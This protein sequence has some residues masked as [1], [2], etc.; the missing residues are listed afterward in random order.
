MKSL[1]VVDSVFGNTEQVARVMHDVLLPF[2]EIALM[3]PDAVSRELFQGVDLLVVGSPTRGFRPTPAITTFL[4]TTCRGAIT[5][6]PV[7]AFDTRY[8]PD[9][10]SWA[11]RSIMRLCGF[12]A[13]FIAKELQKQGGVLVLPPE[14]F[15][16]KDEKGPLDDG[17]LERAARWA[18]QV[19][20]DRPRPA[21]QAGL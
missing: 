17:E 7:A 6:M 8:D 3:R 11:L 21:K 9:R 20:R 1:I 2:G 13:P 5:G 10:R 12:A 18:H 14:G 16:V 4:K 19:A 15:F